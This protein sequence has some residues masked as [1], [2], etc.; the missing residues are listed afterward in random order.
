M[1]SLS[2]SAIGPCA[3]GASLFF[4][5]ESPRTGPI[6]IR[7]FPSKRMALIDEHQFPDQYVDWTTRNESVDNIRHISDLYD[8]FDATN[9]TR[10]TYFSAL[11][12]GGSS[13]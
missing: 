5:D 13:S 10:C 9:C 12:F 6:L 11:A 1:E 8:V 2:G 4:D 3:I 7:R